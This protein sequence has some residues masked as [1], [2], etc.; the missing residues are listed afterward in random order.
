MH[1]MMLEEGREH[2]SGLEPIKAAI[3]KVQAL[4]DGV[5]LSNLRNA[6]KP[7]AVKLEIEAQGEHAEPDGDECPAC[8]DGTCDDPAHLKEDDMESLSSMYGAKKDY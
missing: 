3:A 2:E 8:M 7:K 6:G 1:T 5:E 4:L